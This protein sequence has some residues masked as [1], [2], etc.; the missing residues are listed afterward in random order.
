ML[1]LH[2]IMGAFF[3]PFIT[4]R[5]SPQLGELYET[6]VLRALFLRV[7]FSRNTRMTTFLPESD[8]RPSLSQWTCDVT[9]TPRSWMS[10]SR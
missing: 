4:R 2:G 6:V 10:Q 9:E 1:F 7:G 5:E 3:L 8:V